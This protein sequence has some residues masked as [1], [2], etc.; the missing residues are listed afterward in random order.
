M[1]QS[2]IDRLQTYSGGTTKYTLDGQVRLAKCI[3]VYD[4][5]TITI[6]LDS[7][8][9]AADLESQF[10]V[11][12]ELKVYSCRCY[13]YNSAEI[14]TKDESEKKAA[15]AAKECL[16]KFVLGRIILCK[17]YREDKYGRLLAT[18]YRAPSKKPSNITKYIEKTTSYNQ[19]M[20][21]LKHGTPYFGS[22]PKLYT[23]IAD[24]SDNNKSKEKV[25]KKV[26][27]K[28]NKK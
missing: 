3:K 27:K 12:H 20:V 18:I 9:W 10:S 24:A 1:Y 13:G 19:Q 16:Q 8:N 5:D 14:K 17:F 15:L 4:G 6:I 2:S 21:E 28:V 22:G 23:Q 7:I 26:D 25:D 11:D